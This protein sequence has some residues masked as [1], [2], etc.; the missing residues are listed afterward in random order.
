M[1]TLLAVAGP[2]AAVPRGE[3]MQMN[4]S[5]RLAA[6]DR[7]PIE[8]RFPSHLSLLRARVASAMLVVS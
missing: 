1:P 2:W 6:F 7:I 3:A 8:T 4:R 5:L